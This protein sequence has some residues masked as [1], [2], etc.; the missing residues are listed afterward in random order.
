MNHSAEEVRANLIARLGPQFGID[1]YNLRNA[2]I[3]IRIDWRFY[4]SLFGESPERVALLNDCSG[5]FFYTQERVLFEAVVIGLCRII[6]PIETG[7]GKGI[8]RN[9]T[10]HRL[11]NYISDNA[12]Q[13]AFDELISKAEGAAIF[14]RDWRNKRIAHNDYDISAGVAVLEVAS[15]EKV[16]FLIDVVGKILQWIYLEFLESDIHLDAL[17]PLD[18]EVRVMT[19]LY[20]GLEAERLEEEDFRKA[21]EVGNYEA[22]HKSNNLPEW[23]TKRE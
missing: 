10:F 11:K 4:R 21:I 14:A 7:K 3:G 12:R 9:M 20:K 18:D 15:R 6:D 13:V 22:A 5:L 8:R 17:L 19:L 1:L 16:Q 23:L 2:Y